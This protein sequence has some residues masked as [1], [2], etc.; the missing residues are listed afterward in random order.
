ML[1]YLYIIEINYI[2]LLNAFPGK[3]VNT[4]Q[5]S[6]EL[7]IFLCTSKIIINRYIKKI[8]KNI[9]LK[10]KIINFLK[11]HLASFTQIIYLS[12]LISACE[13]TTN[14][15]NQSLRTNATFNFFAPRL[16]DPIED[17]IANVRR[18]R[19]LLIR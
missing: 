13:V 4:N 7:I 14:Y 11:N 2:Y 9:K 18:P 5:C 17:L 10:H 3:I 6:N 8:K 1:D 12:K 19:R 15:R 16:Y